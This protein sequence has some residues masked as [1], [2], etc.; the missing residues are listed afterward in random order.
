MEENKRLTTKQHW[1]NQ[2]EKYQFKK[3]NGHAIEALIRKFIPPNPLGSCLEVG[4]FPGHFLPILGDLGYTLNGIDFNPKNKDQLPA[5]LE[6]EG[7]K[8]GEFITEDFLDFDSTLKYDTVMSFGFIEHFSN[9]EE[10]LAEHAKMVKDGGYLVITTPNF[11]GM[12]QRWLHQTFDKRN[13]QFHNIESMQP[14]MWQLQLE[15]A[16]FEVL[17]AGHFGGFEF[18]R[19]PDPLSAVKKKALWIIWPMVGR[20]NKL[21]WFNSS[22]FSAYCGVVAQ[23]KKI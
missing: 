7:Y 6:S 8:L 10:L 1:T 16:G 9:Y 17:F 5:W 19:S 4:S 14:G 18:W 13:L 3:H 12:V 23:K 11:R 2:E 15:K 21:L 20:V 22:T